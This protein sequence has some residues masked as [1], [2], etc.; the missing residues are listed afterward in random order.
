MAS[1]PI[2]PTKSA[3]AEVP[4][5]ENE[6]PAYR[7][8]SRAAIAA[9]VFGAASILTFLWPYFA[10]FGALALVCG[11]V[12]Q[13]NIRRLPDILT[14]TRMANAGTALGLLFTLSALTIIGV[15]YWI[16][17]HEA[18]KF[19]REYVEA[20]RSGSIDQAIYFENNPV[21]RE[22]KAVEEIA[23]EYREGMTKGGMFEMQTQGVHDIQKRLSSGPGQTVE[24]GDRISHDF[25]G[26]D[27]YATYLIVLQGPKSKEFPEETQYA[28][29]TLLGTPKGRTYGWQVKNVRFPA[30]M[31]R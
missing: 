28:A 11:L 13:R 20:L 5:I 23:K 16:M 24:L 10:A 17:D 3:E 21:Y 4:V 9:L 22:G 2:T 18:G 12:A 31:P 1:N 29:V 27:A 7:A 30:T 19:A 6:L 14:G 25:E 26:M 8:M 15:Q